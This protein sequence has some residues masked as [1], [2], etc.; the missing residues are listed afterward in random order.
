MSTAFHIFFAI[1]AILSLE[2]SR[3]KASSKPQVFTVTLEGGKKLGG[4]SQV[5]KKNTKSKGKAPSKKPQSKSAKKIQKPS[6]VENKQKEIE[7]KRKLEQKKKKDIELKKKRELELKKKRELEKKKQQELEKKRQ[8]EE[9][10]K[11]E[12]QAKE[13]AERRK[14]LDAEF[15]AEQA[16]RKKEERERKLSEARARAAKGGYEGESANAGGQ[17]FGAARLGG[18]GMGGGTLASAEFIAYRNALERHIKSGWRWIGGGAELEA[19]VSFRIL[20]G[21]ILQDIQ[22]VSS[23]GRSDFD[24]SVI[25]AVYKSSPVP[26]PPESIYSQFRYMKI[27]FDSSRY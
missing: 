21:G 19:Q 3:A 26:A 2:A 4:V 7:R 15:E 5:K 17:G 14:R 22:I 23:S 11:K 16:R 27:I 13:D 6:V 9:R 18:E 25:R 10:L 1:I 24:D 20:P 8:E 12:Q